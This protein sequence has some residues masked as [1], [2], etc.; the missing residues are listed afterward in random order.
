[1]VGIALSL[2]HILLK[3]PINLGGENNTQGQYIGTQTCTWQIHAKNVTVV[4]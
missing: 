3:T 1:M 2:G 4:D